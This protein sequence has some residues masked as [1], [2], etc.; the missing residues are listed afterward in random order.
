M[1][2][3][4]QVSKVYRVNKKKFQALQDINLYIPRG[5]IFGVLGKS[6]AGKS[7]L[8]RTVNLLERPSSGQV[9]VNG[10]DLTT[11][12]LDQLREHRHKIGVIFQ[13]Y[14]LLESRSV[15]GNI[16][17]PL[18][19]IGKSG[20]EIQEKVTQ[21]LDLVG[22]SDQKNHLPSQLSGGQKQRVGIARALAM[23]PHILL[24]D[25]A[26]SAL[27]SESTNTVL[28]LLKKIN[29]ELGLTILL[30]TH[31]LDV[32]KKICDRVGI[33]DQG[34]LVEQDSTVAIFSNPKATIT[35]QLIQQALHFYE[36]TAS[37]KDALI[38]KLT[39]IG[40]ASD[41]PLISSLVRKFD[42][43]F[44][45]KQALIEKVQDTTIGFTICALTGEKAA[46]EKALAYIHS[47]PIKAETLY[48]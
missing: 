46:L 1:I 2:E 9:L 30:I 12:S 23:G 20:T 25:E 29:R 11:L 43:T 34:C 4:R 42:I 3:L 47:T 38:I 37:D 27:D 31:E 36:P 40:E 5:E 19:V 24:C 8:L 10:V 16:S 15:F 32:V 22:L 44:N 28:Q 6:G 14:N 13:H 39:F 7:T 45:I 48:A 35:K 26:T 17:L 18:E 41:E 21:L 33:I